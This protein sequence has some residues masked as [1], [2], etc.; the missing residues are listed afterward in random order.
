LVAEE[1]P[2]ALGVIASGV[3]EDAP[4]LI[5]Y[6]GAEAEPQLPGYAAAGADESEA[7]GP[8]IDAYMLAVR[9]DGPALV[10]ATG[11]ESDATLVQAQDLARVN[12]EAVTP[13]EAERQSADASAGRLSL[14]YFDPAR[15]YQGG[16]QSAA[17][18][19]PSVREETID[20]PAAMSAAQALQT[21]TQAARRRNRGRRTATV[22]RG[23]P[24]LGFRPGDLVGLG[25]NAGQWRIEALEWEKMAVRLSLKAVPSRALGTVGAADAGA[26]VRQADNP[27]G[28]THLALIELPQTSDTPTSAPQVAVAACGDGRAWRPAALFLR[29]DAAGG[30]EDLGLS[31]RAAALGVT[32]SVLPDGPSTLFDGAASVVVVL[33][34]GDQI[35][36]PANDAALLGGANACMVGGELMQFGTVQQLGPRTFRLGRLLRGRRGTERFRSAHV[37]GERFVLL[38]ADSLFVLDGDVARA[39]RTITIAAQGIGDEGLVQESFSVSGQALLPLAPVHV[40]VIGSAAGGLS[41]SW[42]R[43]S[44]LGWQWLDGSDAPLGEEREAYALEILAGEDPIRSVNADDS[45]WFYPATA[46]VDD[47]ALAGGPLSVRIRQRGTYGLGEAAAGVLPI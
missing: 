13:R 1:A 10:L 38:R 3:A 46:I 14:R 9:P 21:V 33:Y 26:S 31:A 8:L 37:V 29:E 16:V 15:D 18:G 19:G 41:I 28:P 45:G 42:V 11:L 6:A 23:W 7:L 35:L 22:H 34:D 12:G 43:R 24:A 17:G 44:R 25:G 36:A 2:V 20:L 5:G 27:V 47:L 30:F 40:R 39:G 4:G 32:A